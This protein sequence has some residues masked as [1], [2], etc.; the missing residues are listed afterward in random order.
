MPHL[1]SDWPLANDPAAR[2]WLHL[3]GSHPVESRLPGS[4]CW[5]LPRSQCPMQSP[6]VSFHPGSACSCRWF[7]GSSSRCLFSSFGFLDS[8]F[9]LDTFLQLQNAGCSNPQSHMQSLRLLS[10]FFFLS[11]SFLAAATAF[12][13]SCAAL[14]SLLGSARSKQRSRFKFWLSLRIT[15]TL[16]MLLSLLLDAPHP[17]FILCF[18]CCS[19]G[20]RCCCCRLGVDHRCRHALCLRH[21]SL[22]SLLGFAQP[23]MPWHCQC[24]VQAPSTCGGR[25]GPSSAVAMPDTC[26]LVAAVFTSSSPS[27]GHLASAWI[28][29]EE[30]SSTSSSAGGGSR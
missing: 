13:A 20:S 25:S 10:C 26:G 21:L 28:G 12:S 23:F 29:G 30:G 4:E 14:R 19:G 15:L 3:A 7:G 11:S 16:C 8:T 17:C 5:N 27:P 9:L 6:Q 24:H 18:R 1:S 22:G 2:P